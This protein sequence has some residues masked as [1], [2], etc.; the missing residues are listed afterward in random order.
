MTCTGGGAVILWRA[1]AEAARLEP[2]VRCLVAG[3]MDSLATDA[4]QDREGGR[5][6]GQYRPRH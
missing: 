3:L 6:R 4:A 1:D 5:G 2:L